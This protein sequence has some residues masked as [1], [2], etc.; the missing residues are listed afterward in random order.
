MIIKINLITRLK[1]AGDVLKLTFNLF[2][3]NFTRRLECRC[4]QLTRGA[5]QRTLKINKISSW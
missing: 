5:S 1:Q 2:C 3:H 4:E